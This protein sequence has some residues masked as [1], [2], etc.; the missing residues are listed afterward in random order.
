MINCISTQIHL[1]VLCTV[2]QNCFLTDINNAVLYHVICE[3]L[4]SCFMFVT[5]NTLI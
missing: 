3:E 4:P 5:N 1:S 2:L